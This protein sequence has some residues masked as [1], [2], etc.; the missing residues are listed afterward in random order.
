[1]T[2]SDVLTFVAFAIDEMGSPP[3]EGRTGGAK[4]RARRRPAG[5]SFGT[6]PKDALT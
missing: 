3:G 6:T 2:N 1:L 5:F 4:S